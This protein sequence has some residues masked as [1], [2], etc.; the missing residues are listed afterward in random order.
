MTAGE[1]KP[2]DVNG[3]TLHYLEQGDGDPV[4][5]VHGSAS[6]HRTWD[7]H[8]DWLAAHYRT[9]TYSRRYH[10]PNDRIPDGAD[11]SMTEHADDLTALLDALDMAPASL[12]GHSYGAFVCLLVAM[13]SP[14]R[15]RK[16]VLAEPPAITLFVSN[17]PKPGELAKLFLTRPRTAAAIVRFGARGVVPAAAA[18]RRDDMDAALRIFGTAVLGRDTF[19]NLSPARLEQARANQI[20]AELLGSG[21]PP[22]DDDAIRRVDIPVLLINGQ[23][24]PKLFHRLL[25]R[26]EE[27][28]PNT[29]RMEISGASH[30]MHE[31]NP[32]AWREAV[33]SFL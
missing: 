14:E 6:D 10:W 28:L 26:L 15:V 30:I 22:L 16:L 9:I 19:R 25:D 20:K 24:S 1:V 18:M 5:L 23:S 27:L 33:Q 8:R 2:I 13:R 12:V 3:A 31:D 29:S 4:V 7:P 32:P 17:Q 21:F 11:Y